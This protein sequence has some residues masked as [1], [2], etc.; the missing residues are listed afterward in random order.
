[1]GTTFYSLFCGDNLK[2]ALWKGGM[3]IV[4]TTVSVSSLIGV[5][6]DIPIVVNKIS[7]GIFGMGNSLTTTGIVASFSHQ[8]TNTKKNHTQN[9]RKSKSINK[10]SAKKQKERALRYFIFK[11]NQLRER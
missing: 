1:M 8:K 4:C 9:Q 3:T 11:M 7:T 5:K 6:S 10:N 2:T